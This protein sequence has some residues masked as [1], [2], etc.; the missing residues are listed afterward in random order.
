MRA[1][2]L[3]ERLLIELAKP[4]E[5]PLNRRIYELVRSAITGG[6]LSPGTRLPSSRDLARDLNVSRNTVVSAIDQLLAE[7]YVEARVG[8]GTY[9]S[10][11]LPEQCGRAKSASATHAAP[12][13]ALSTA[14]R[15]LS[16]RG[17]RLTGL[18]GWQ[19]LEVQPF[20]P[21]PADYATLQFRHW[22][23]LLKK[24][25]N[26]PNPDLLDCG[27]PGGYRPLRE[28]IARY[29][30]VSRS[31]NVVAEQV[32][33]TSSTQQSVDLC[34]RLLADP[35]DLV[36]MENPGYWGAQRALE[37]A[38]LRLVPIAVDEEGIAPTTL[39]WQAPPRM[40]YLTPSNQYPT[41]AV[42]SLERRRRILEFAAEHNIWILEDDYDSEFRYEGRP[43]PS[44]QGMDVQERVL[45]LGTF[46]KVMYQGVRL[47]YIVVP[48]DLIERFRI[49]LYD[50]F[51][52]GQLTMQAALSEFIDE[53]HFEVNLRRMRVVY[54]ERRAIL[55]ATLERILGD[56]VHLSR[57]NAGMTL[58]IHLP[59]GSDDRAIA[60]A[61]LKASL[62]V[63]AL[64]NY[65]L[66][67]ERRAGLVVGFAYVSTP[68]IVPYAQ[69]LARIILEELQPKIVPRED[70]SR[71]AATL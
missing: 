61:A 63:R 21:G 26:D 37:A 33:I 60:A 9:V 71:L 52:P 49:G 65:Y 47:A 50:L 56:K 59:E 7:G 68:D 4:Y 67:P 55:R 41:G 48:T 24:Y 30:R 57:S 5:L 25:V 8:S 53:G 2:A 36:W 44:L 18:A 13:L 46:S 66:T 45:Y 64:S 54:G 27:D 29:L 23:R 38:D 34:A 1:L 3:S 20:A 6:M 42:M 22:N 58:V 35:G 32:L 10:V 51:R 16:K 43:L 62:T 11:L 69:V 17:L 40:I 14:P 28:A 39:D 31:V 12:G 19:H 15:R 70:T